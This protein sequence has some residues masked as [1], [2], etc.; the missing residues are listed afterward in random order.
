MGY[1]IKVGGLLSSERKPVMYAMQKKVLRGIYVVAVEAT[2]SDNDIEIK[3]WNCV[4]P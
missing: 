2:T 1:L 3:N 4:K